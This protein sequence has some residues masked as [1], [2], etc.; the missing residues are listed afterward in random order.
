MRITHQN[1]KQLELENR[2]RIAKLCIQR[3]K[4]A[5]N[6]FVCSKQNEYLIRYRYT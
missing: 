6:Y 2:F 5:T 1:Q 3:V 4:N